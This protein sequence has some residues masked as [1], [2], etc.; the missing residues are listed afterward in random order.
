VSLS[1]ERVPAVIL[2]GEFGTRIRHLL[3]DLPKPMA[4]VLGRPFLE[5][6]VRFLIEQGVKRIVI[7][8]GYKAETIERYFSEKHWNGIVIQC[9][10]EAEPL[11]TAGG[12]LNAVRQ[13]GG[14]P[15]AWLILNGDS[16]ILT[17]LKP[18][19]E[20]IEDADA[21]V[22]ILGVNVTDA[23]RYGTLEARDG[24]LT[25]FAEKK[26]GKATINA[27]VYLFGVEVLGSF[28]NKTPLSFEQDVFPVILQKGHSVG[29]VAV[30]APFLDIGTE[31]SLK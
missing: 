9:V 21:D 26:P 6:V 15:P 18:L 25:R 22:C 12:F 7:S 19:L 31:A 29:I 3:L 4:P 17:G 28:P 30:E 10:R 5:W 23:S 11:G 2:A 14:K 1:L 24:R 13:S 16:L 8:T 20:R 27:G